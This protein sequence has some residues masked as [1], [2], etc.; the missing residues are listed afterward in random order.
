MRCL[1]L[2]LGNS[3]HEA[4]RLTGNVYDEI[5]GNG[6][7]FEK[8]LHDGDQDN[9]GRQLLAS[10]RVTRMGNEAVCLMTGE[11]TG[12]GQV[13]KLKASNE[14]VFFKTPRLVTM[15]KSFEEESSFKGGRLVTSWKF[16]RDSVSRI[17]KVQDGNAPNDLGGTRGKTSRD[18]NTILTQ[19]LSH[20]AR[21]V[22]TT[23]TRGD[24]EEGD[25]EDGVLTVATAK[26]NS[27]ARK[28]WWLWSKAGT[29][30][31]KDS[32][33]GWHEAVVARTRFQCEGWLGYSAWW[34]SARVFPGKE[35]GDTEVVVRDGE[36]NWNATRLGLMHGVH[37]R[38]GTRLGCARV[39]GARACM[40]PACACMQ[41]ETWARKSVK[42][43]QL[44]SYVHKD[45]VLREVTKG[46]DVQQDSDELWIVLQISLSVLCTSSDNSK[47]LWKALQK[48]FEGNSDIKKSKRDLLRKQYECFRFL[49]N[50]SLNDLISRF[51]HLQTELKAFELKYP[52]E[53][54]VEKFLDA[55][56]PRFEMYTTLIRENPKFFEMTVEE[57]IENVT[58][59][60]MAESSGRDM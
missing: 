2:Y 23:E 7:E 44:M 40:A 27:G 52:D 41:A 1:C 8:S 12:E 48:R 37:A 13:P 22:H 31:T 35:D 4:K 20:S 46:D 54:L 18:L 14:E 36:G 26:R 58:P 34:C 49:E 59:R 42:D 24:T 6:L 50:E 17:S 51:Y 53:E 16:L 33:R 56:P 55:L 19:T 11:T 57:A 60:P 47:D 32:R 10:A 21:V 29:T 39:C 43:V 3:E 15:W 9:H 5:K 45:E 38:M 30:V 25:A 28:R